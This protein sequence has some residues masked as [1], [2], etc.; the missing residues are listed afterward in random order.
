[1]DTV[2]L[3]SI[4]AMAYMALGL[5][6]FNLIPGALLSIFNATDNILTIG[7]AALRTISLSFVFAGFGIVTSNFCQAL[8]KSIYSLISSV[9]RQLV[10]LIP[11]AY[12][13]A[14]TGRVEAV[15]WAFPISEIMSLILSIFFFLRVS[16][17]LV[18]KG[19]G[20]DEPEI[21]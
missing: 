15:W 3:S 13:L 5:I 7:K 9:G 18:P 12:L 19:F 16:H 20:E 14:L 1:M 4:A 10:V 11:V 17:K 2:R 8:G 6:L 21:D